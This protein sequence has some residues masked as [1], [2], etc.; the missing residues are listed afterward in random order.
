MTTAKR[1]GVFGAFVMA[2][3][4]GLPGIASA[5][6]SVS[7]RFANV[8]DEPRAEGSWAWVDNYHGVY[9][10][11]S[12]R[13]LT[14]GETYDVIAW[15]SFGDAGGQR[16]VARRGANSGRVQFVMNSAPQWI[17]VY[18]VDGADRVLV[19]AWPAP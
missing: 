5:Q 19:L 15:N 11:V 10:D 6:F 13:R 18:R 17:Y 2:L 3:I 7:G 16:F 1:N 9:V 14:P 8:G 4:L 12:C